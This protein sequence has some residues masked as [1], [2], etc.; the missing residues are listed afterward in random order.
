M[1]FE[2]GSSTSIT[3]ILA[4]RW[5][6]RQVKSARGSTAILDTRR[7]FPQGGSKYN[8]FAS[9]LLCSHAPICCACDPFR[10]VVMHDV[11]RSARRSD[12]ASRHLTTQTNVTPT[13]RINAEDI[14]RTSAAPPT[15]Q[16]FQFF[17]L[18]PDCSGVVVHMGSTKG[19]CSL[20]S[21]SARAPFRVHLRPI[22]QIYEFDHGIDEVRHRP[23]HEAWLTKKHL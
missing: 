6:T 15:R 22:P 23:D 1:S 3:D 18:P 9:P 14:R 2:P 4:Y 16:E 19:T 11:V 5:C 20:E 12:S 10:H 13:T 17:D 8:I 7:P 21:D